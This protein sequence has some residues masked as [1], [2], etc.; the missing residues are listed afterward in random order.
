MTDNTKKGDAIP[1]GASSNA[2]VVTAAADAGDFVAARKWGWR[3][4]AIILLTLVAV[5]AVADGQIQRRRVRAAENRIEA[6]GAIVA[7]TWKPWR[8]FGRVGA[9]REALK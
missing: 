3:D 2:P 8:A 7:P 9:V 4:I 6:V 1:Q 5:L